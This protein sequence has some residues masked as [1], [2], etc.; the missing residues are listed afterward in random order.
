MSRIFKELRKHYSLIRH[1]PLRDE[2]LRENIPIVQPMLHSRR[3]GLVTNFV[4]MADRGVLAPM[5]LARCLSHRR[6][7]G[8]YPLA[9]SGLPPHRGPNSWVNGPGI[10]CS[11]SSQRKRGMGGDETRGFSLVELLIVMAV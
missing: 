10:P 3:S 2:Y 11:P 8:T 7:V 9:G 6:K 1:S 4:S 5:L